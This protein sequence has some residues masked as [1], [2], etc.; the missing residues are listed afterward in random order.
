M[1][2]LKHPEPMTLYVDNLVMLKP[3][4]A[5]M[6]CRLAKSG[7]YEARCSSMT[8]PPDALFDEVVE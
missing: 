6:Y 3:D 8:V 7:E 1:F 5:V 2:Q 4:E